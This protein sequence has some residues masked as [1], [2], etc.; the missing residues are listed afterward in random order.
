MP[1]EPDRTSVL[2]KDS[3]TPISRIRYYP[4]G[5]PSVIQNI[6]C[7][8]LFVMAWWSGPARMGFR[9]LTT[10]LA[11][12]DPDGK[13]EIVVVDTDGCPELYHL[14]E[15]RDINRGNGVTA[16]V[17]HGQ[18]LLAVPCYTGQPIFGS[19]LDALCTKKLG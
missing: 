1:S 5:D 14:S 7:G 9:K 18:V 6:R 8:V 2:A 3:A 13:V 11:R 10:D 16:A 15:L 12:I 17:K 19:L 4:F